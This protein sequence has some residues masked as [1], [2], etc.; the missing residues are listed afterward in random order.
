MNL[1]AIKK[2]LNI[3]V[4]TLINLYF[5]ISFSYFFFLFDMDIKKMQYVV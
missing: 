2:I 1:A 5:L 3:L 4:Y